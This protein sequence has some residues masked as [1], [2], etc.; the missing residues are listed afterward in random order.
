[1]FPLIGPEMIDAWM[2][3]PGDDVRDAD[4]VEAS[5]CGGET[6]TVTYTRVEIAWCRCCSWST[7]SRWA[8]PKQPIEDTPCGSIFDRF[9]KRIGA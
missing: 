8:A 1:M 9:R 4:T 2:R 7:T 3:R 5:Q 6:V